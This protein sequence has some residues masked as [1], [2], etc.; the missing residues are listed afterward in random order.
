M[1]AIST[2]CI[3]ENSAVLA[4]HYLNVQLTALY[5]NALH[6][7]THHP[8]TKNLEENSQI[9]Q[10]NLPASG[11]D[12]LF[13]AKFDKPV[14]EFIC[15]HDAILR[16]KVKEG[17]YNLGHKTYTRTTA[18]DVK[19]PADLE[20]T[21]RFGFDVRKIIGQDSKIENGQNLIQLV[22]LD[23]KNAKLI[24]SK[25]ELH[26]GTGSALA[27]RLAEGEDVCSFSSSVTLKE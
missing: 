27:I 24:S 19:L 4:V 3:G 20:L 22:I 1:L 23:L 6:C 16:L 2:M 26:M 5:E 11:V 14:L 17:H 13:Y 10:P 12:A 9:T 25:P 21:F 7:L 15:K 8:D 18:E